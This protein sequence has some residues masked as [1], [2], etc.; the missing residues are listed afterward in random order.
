MP[1]YWQKKE[2]HRVKMPLHVADLNSLMSI[3]ETGMF[4]GKH[5]PSKETFLVLLEQESNRSRRRSLDQARFTFS[6]ISSKKNTN[7]ISQCFHTYNQT[8][9]LKKK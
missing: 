5:M 7:S 9:N 2:A 1:S 4:I 8:Q 3:L 6:Q